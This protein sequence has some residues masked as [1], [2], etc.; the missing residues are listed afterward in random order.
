MG[1]GDILL[2]LFISLPLSCLMN[3]HADRPTANKQVNKQASKQADKTAC[4]QKKNVIVFLLLLLLLLDAVSLR[5]LSFLW[6]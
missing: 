6:I 2:S 1:Q 5:V 3:V 4:E